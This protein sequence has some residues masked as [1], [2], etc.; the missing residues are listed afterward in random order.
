M[1][2]ECSDCMICAQCIEGCGG[3]GKIV[4]ACIICVLGLYHDYLV[5]GNFIQFGRWYIHTTSMYML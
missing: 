2:I 4:L 5:V 1:S 3:N